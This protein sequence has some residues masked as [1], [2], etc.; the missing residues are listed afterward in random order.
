MKKRYLIISAALIATC[1]LLIP[2]CGKNDAIAEEPAQQTETA[3][4]EKNTET[5]EEP[6]VSEI[7]SEEK[8]EDR[9]GVN[10]EPQ[11]P[12]EEETSSRSVTVYYVD[13]LSGV[14]VGKAAEITDEYDIWNA[15]KENGILTDECELNSI[16]INDDQTMDLDFNHATADRIN[17]MGTTGE[18]EIIGC[19]VNTYLD[20]YDCSGIRLLEEGKD[21]V[22]SHGAVFDKYPG[23]IEFK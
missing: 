16:R 13:D 21:F 17:S 9:E 12:V 19:I 22:S 15:L 14:V 10:S 2:G 3:D 7:D 6:S 18:T 20:A 8:T 11:T 1:G 23:R 4:D 5:E